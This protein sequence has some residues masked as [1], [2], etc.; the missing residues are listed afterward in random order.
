MKAKPE[1]QRAARRLRATGMP[2]KQI[3]SLLEISPGSVHLWTK[4]IPISDDQ[5][6]ENRRRAAR[7]RNVAW[8]ERHRERRRGYQDEGRR[9]AREGDAFHQAGCMLYWAEGS[10]SRNSV[11]LANSDPNL[12]RFFATF[13]KLSFG[14]GRAD[15]TV[16]FNVY[17]NNGLTIEEIEDYWLDVLDLPRECLRKH[18]VDYLPTSSSGQKRHR[19]PYGVCHLR[20]HDTRIVQHIY[21]AIQEYGGFDEPRWLDCAPRRAP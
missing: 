15:V 1:E 5:T 10:K 14:V 12:M 3:A 7:I 2:M 9:R 13:L 18:I 8:A 16:N 17:L 19:L 11:D 6:K 21:G 4:D 20:V